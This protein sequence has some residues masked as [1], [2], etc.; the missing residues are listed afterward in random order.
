MRNGEAFLRAN[1]QAPPSPD[2][3]ATITDPENE[4]S[5]S[6]VPLTKPL[7]VK[8]LR[9][10]Q[11]N[12]QITQV[13]ISLTTNLLIKALLTKAIPA[14]V[15]LVTV[16]LEKDFLQTSIL[17]HHFAPNT[18][19]CRIT[20]RPSLPEEISGQASLPRECTS[21]PNGS[22]PNADLFT[23]ARVKKILQI[24]EDT[25]KVSN[26]AAF[27]ITIATVRIESHKSCCRTLLIR[28][29]N[30]HTSLS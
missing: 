2:S 22:M 10:L 24:D 11:A 26:N 12:V 20:M 27:V 5:L 25:V 15:R 7:P 19:K 14:K 18:P 30:V 29:G 21:N 4:A 6:E 8:I 9:T 13:G 3:D 28:L 23:V 16:R 1:A 17:T